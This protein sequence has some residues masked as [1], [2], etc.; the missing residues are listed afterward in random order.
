MDWVCSTLQEH[1]SPLFRKL[2]TNIK[3]GSVVLIDHGFCSYHNIALCL[4]Y[5]LDALMYLHSLRKV[6][7][8]RGK[9][10]GKQ[11]RLMSWSRESRNKY[12]SKR[13]WLA[14]PNTLEVRVCR[15]Q[16]KQNGMRTQTLWIATTLT[17]PK[18]YLKQTLAELYQCR[19]QVELFLRDIKTSMKPLA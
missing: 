3:S 9:R 11:D 12:W 18:L 19:W 2:V 16:V 4:Q 7:L 17:D 1:E 5:Q 8:R 10:L 15:F 6:D 14:L 13:D